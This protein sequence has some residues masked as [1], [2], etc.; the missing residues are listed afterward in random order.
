MEQLKVIA[1][2]YENQECMKKIE[3]LALYKKS[4]ANF[5]AGHLFF[6]YLI[7]TYLLTDCMN[8]L[9]PDMS[10]QFYY[11]Y[12]NFSLY[13]N[14]LLNACNM[15]YVM[16][17]AFSRECAH[18]ILMRITNILAVLKILEI[19]HS[20]QPDINITTLDFLKFCLL[21]FMYYHHGM[22]KVNLLSSG[23]SGLYMVINYWN[24]MLEWP[25]INFLLSYFYYLSITNQMKYVL[26][27]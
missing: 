3:N 4:L 19:N 27:I 17:A 7:N 24:M 9:W 10:S 26:R 18:K 16:Q 2:L 1:K 6:N 5:C 22:D 11:N 14:V 21:H 23:L 8:K 13:I 12:G 20:I 25:R 15:F